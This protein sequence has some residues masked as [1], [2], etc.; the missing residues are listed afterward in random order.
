M[1]QTWLVAR[2]DQLGERA[3]GE[4]RYGV[5]HTD[6]PYGEDVLW[7]VVDEMADPEV[8]KPVVYYDYFREHFRAVAWA[9]ALNAAYAAGQE[10]R[11]KVWT[12]H[13]WEEEPARIRDIEMGVEAR[14]KEL[15]EAARVL[16]VMQREEIA[17]DW[18]SS[19]TGE[20]MV[21][22]NAPP[23]LMRKGIGPTIIAAVQDFERR[24]KA[25]GK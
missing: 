1:A 11:D 16:E 9:A 4:R 6:A 2:G 22:N 24:R 5:R 18:S 25:A 23:W 15:R 21:T 19:K 8:G 14:M 10:Y 3:W 13:L 12:D 20:I 7:Y 17:P